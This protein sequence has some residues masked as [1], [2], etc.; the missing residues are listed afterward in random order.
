MELFLKQEV[1]F[2]IVVDEIA[3]RSVATSAFN[4]AIL[5]EFEKLV[6]KIKFDNN[7]RKAFKKLSGL[8]CDVSLLTKRDF[9]RLTARE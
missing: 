9:V 8:N 4:E 1:Y 5:P 3:D 2:R 7:D 6:R